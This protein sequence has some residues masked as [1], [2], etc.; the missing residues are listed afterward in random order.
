MPWGSGQLNL[1]RRDNPKKE[2]HPE[3]A[4]PV[5]RPDVVPANLHLPVLSLVL[6][7]DQY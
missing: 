3:I 2:D 7:V 1:A 4:G 5:T 6:L